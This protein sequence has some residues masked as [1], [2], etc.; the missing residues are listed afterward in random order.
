MLRIGFFV[1]HFPYREPFSKEVNGKYF[2]GG[3][4][5]AAYNL[6]INLM[7]RGHNVEIFT[8]SADSKDTLE[9][10]KNITVYR[11][12]RTLRIFDTYFSVKLLYEPS[13]YDL[14][15]VHAHFSTFPGPLA[16]FL[17]LSKKTRPPSERKTPFVITYHL[18][19]I[20]SYGNP[21]RRASV[22]L[23]QRFLVNT[24]LQRADCIIA[25]SEAFIN[26]SRILQRYR[27][28]I[29]IIPNGINFDEFGRDLS[30]MDSKAQLGLS[31]SDFIILSVG[32]LTERK[33][34]DI[35][36]KAVSRVRERIPNV[37][38]IFVGPPL[39]RLK[40]LRALA[41]KLRLDSVV[42]FKGFVDE[43]EKRLYLASADV[44]VSPSYEE[45]WGLSICEAMA[46][47]LPVIVSNLEVFGPII[48]DNRD[49]VFA[50]RGDWEDFARKISYILE[51]DDLREMMSRT[52][53]KKVEIFSWDKITSE[54]EKT[55]LRVLGRSED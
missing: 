13:E 14:D 11:Y 23:Y 55:Y 50:K 3:E 12:G 10:Y 1:T 39:G 29:E 34:P 40:N 9:K 44:F 53:K 35:L 48:T 19:P 2:S 15:I 47:G 49:G 30:K 17:Y 6:A 45:S 5:E 36:L 38:L 41:R 26:Q 21:L 4:G 22:L 42:D 27:D 46:C 43:Y 54:T 28:K 18:D 52:A 8:T 20:A 24:I 25:F 51:N 32:S 7:K 33:G 31:E 16:A 37:R